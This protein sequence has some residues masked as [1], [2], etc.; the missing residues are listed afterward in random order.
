MAA[1]AVRVLDVEDE[2]NA[3]YNPLYG[4]MSTERVTLPIAA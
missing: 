1:A 3:H 4:L 2:R